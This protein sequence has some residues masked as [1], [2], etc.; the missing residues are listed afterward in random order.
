MPVC[1][2]SVAVNRTWTNAVGERQEQVTWF[3]VSARR[4]PAEICAQ[5]LTK[6]DAPLRR[7]RGL[8][9]HRRGGRQRRLHR[10]VGRTHPGWRGVEHRRHHRAAQ[11][12]GFG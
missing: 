4:R 7:Q 5:Y 1:N 12:D 11:A 8:G 9:H 3:Q 2:F 6:G 10:R